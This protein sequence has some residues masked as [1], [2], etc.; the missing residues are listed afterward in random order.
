M[1]LAET[2]ADRPSQFLLGV[3]PF[4]HPAKPTGDVTTIDRRARRCDVT[5]DH[6]LP[7][8]SEDLVVAIRVNPRATIA[9][10]PEVVAPGTEC[11]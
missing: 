4:Q 7:L 2:R 3:V 1:L 5:A 9:V 6:H 8:T 11:P 10:D